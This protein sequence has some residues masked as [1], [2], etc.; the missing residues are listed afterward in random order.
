M[1]KKVLTNTLILFG[2]Q[3]LQGSMNQVAVEFSADEVED[4]TFVNDTH[5]FL[6]GLF[7]SVIGGAGF[8]DAAEPDATL[9]QSIGLDGVPLSVAES[10]IEGTIAYFM[11][12]MLG[13]Y[14]PHQGN[15]G[16]M[17]AFNLGAGARDKL[18]RGRLF[19]NTTE[20]I[21]GNGANI[22]LGAVAAGQGVYSA[23]HVIA[24]SGTTPTLDVI[25]QSDDAGAFTTPITR[26]T[27]PQQIGVGSSFVKALGAV[28]DDFWRLSWTIGGTSP[29]FS[30]MGLVGIV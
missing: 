7:S 22:Q 21:S 4:S 15:I 19:D 18:V 10:P 12:A 23:L 25:V 14:S 5:T 8:F 30:F 3:S 9:F 27:H 13:E 17:L 28:T 29:S 6:G 11:N 1:A 20:T 2:G 26:L 24:A 16:E